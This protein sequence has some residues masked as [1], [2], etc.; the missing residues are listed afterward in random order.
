[1]T[2]MTFTK[3]IGENSTEFSAAFKVW[4]RD[5]AAKQTDPLI[6]KLEECGYN[7]HEA[8][9][10]RTIMIRF[11]LDL[12]K[13]GRTLGE[14]HGWAVRYAQYILNGGT[15]HNDEESTPE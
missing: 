12:H 9:L 3:W 10:I 2:Q 1:M 14:R 6:I 7:D 15:P 13:D 11:M 5:Q 4:N 8:R